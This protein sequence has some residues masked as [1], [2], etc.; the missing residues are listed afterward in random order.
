[1]LSRLIEAYRTLVR[2]CG[3]LRA[4]RTPIEPERRRTALLQCD[5]APALTNCYQ[6]TSIHKGLS[7]LANMA[8]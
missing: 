4:A 7:L 5:I 2:A 8:T 6:H 1:M 3:L